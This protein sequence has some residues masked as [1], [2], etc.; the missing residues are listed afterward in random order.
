A[1]SNEVLETVA[2]EFALA[3]DDVHLLGEPALEAVAA[4]VED[5][6]PSAHL[7]L[8]GRAPLP[9]PLARL[10]ALRAVEVDE[11]RLAFTVDEASALV[12]AIAGG[13]DERV[14]AALHRRTEGWPAGLILAAQ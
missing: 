1:L 3:L 8:A 6:P 14:V 2:D 9:F 5:L 12:A 4:L 11:R 10:R 7:A 13:A